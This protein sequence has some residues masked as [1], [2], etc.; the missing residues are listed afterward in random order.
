MD[1]LS[2]LGIYEL[3]AGAILDQP[4][5]FCIIIYVWIWLPKCNTSRDTL[6]G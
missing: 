5:G 1:H 6:L 2:I 3:G 4:Y